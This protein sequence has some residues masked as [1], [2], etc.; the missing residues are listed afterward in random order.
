MRSAL[1]DDGLFE[2]VF[3]GNG[4]PFDLRQVYDVAHNM[5]KIEW[6]E[7]DGKRM[8][9]CVHRKGATRAFGPGVE[10][11]PPDYRAVGQPVLV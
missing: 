4:L 7:V 5:G 10:G 2:R 1:H 8:Q 6:H 9:V 3:A 11:L